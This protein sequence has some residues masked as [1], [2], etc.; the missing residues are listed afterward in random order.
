MIRTT[1]ILLLASSV[2]L[3]QGR[4]RR[5]GAQLLQEALDAQMRPGPGQTEEDAL[6]R[7]F[8]M[9]GKA[10]EA[11]PRN[12]VVA[13]QDEDFEALLSDPDY[14]SFFVSD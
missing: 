14:A 10:I 11:D 5:A 3:A 6:D 1:L 4:G 2:I 9:M 12:R 8:L 7:A 13:G